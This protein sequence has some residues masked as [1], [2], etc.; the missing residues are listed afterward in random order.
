MPSNLSLCLFQFL[1]QSASLLLLGC[2]LTCKLIKRHIFSLNN[3][4]MSV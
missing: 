4:T 2:T 3:A 1:S